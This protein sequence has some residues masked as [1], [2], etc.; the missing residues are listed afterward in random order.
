ME[1]KNVNAEKLHLELINNGIKPIA[2]EHN[3]SDN[4]Y[5]A[6]TVWITFEKD[7]D[8]E[9]VQQ[10]IDEHDP[11]PLPPKPTKEELLELKLAQNT[12]ETIELLA[13]LYE[14]QKVE[15]AQANAE[16]IELML[17]LTGGV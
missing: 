6:S 9:L 10:I 16:L 7:T 13:T 8:M 17:S 4:E 14:Q 2:V 11:T 12:A 3:T 5:I 15:Q 1:I